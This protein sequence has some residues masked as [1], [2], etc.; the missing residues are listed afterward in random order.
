MKN[1][2]YSKIKRTLAGLLLAML[3]II[4][5]LT[6]QGMSV[7]AEDDIPES[8]VRY[9][10]T[11]PDGTVV[12]ENAEGEPLSYNDVQELLKPA[13]WK[14]MAEGL[15]S[16]ANGKVELD[17]A[18][19]EGT[20]RIVETKVPAGYTQGDDSE[21]TAE[22]EDGTVKFVNPKEKDPEPESGATYEITYDLNGGEYDGST[23]DIVEYYKEG[24][25]ISIHEAPERKGYEF[26]YWKG[27]EY[28]PGDSYTVTEDHT[29]TAQ[30][31]KETTTTT[32]TSG[33]T[34]TGDGN[35]LA[36]YILIGG[37]AAAIF[38]FLAFKKKK[39]RAG[40]ISMM[41][42]GVFAIGA[43]YAA[44]GF[45]INKIDD[46]GDPVKG[47]VFDIYGKPEVT[48][49]DIET[50][51]INGKKTWPDD[52]AVKMG[53]TIPNSI[54]VT[55]QKKDD[56][57]KDV[58]TKTVSKNAATGMWTYDF[59][60]QPKYNNGTEIEYRVVE[61]PVAGY[62][63]SGGTAADSY[64]LTNEYDSR[65]ITLTK[66]WAGDSAAPSGT[67]PDEFM[68]PLYLQLYR[69]DEHWV[70]DAPT[71]DVV[72]NGDN[73][74]T[75]TYTVPR[76]D[77]NGTEYEYR[78]EE[79]NI[80]NYVEGEITGS[81]DNGFAVTNTYTAPTPATVTIHGQKKWVFGA[82]PPHGFTVPESIRV[83]LMAKNNDSGRWS[84]AVPVTGSNP[85][86]VSIDSDDWDIYGDWTSLDISEGE[87]TWTV[88]EKDSKGR[89][90]EYMVVEDTVPY[91]SKTG[92][93]AT[94]NYN[95]T[96][97]YDSSLY[98]ISFIAEYELQGTSGTWSDYISGN[99]D[100]VVKNE[101]GQQVAAFNF[102][103]KTGGITSGSANLAPGHYTVEVT[104]L[105]ADD[106]TIPEGSV[107]RTIPYQG[108]KAGGFTVD[109][110]GWCVA[111]EEYFYEDATVLI[112]TST[113]T[114]SVNAQTM[115][116][117]IGEFIMADGMEGNEIDLVFR[118]GSVDDHDV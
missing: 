57:W 9:T 14:K 30:W 37:A 73:T 25:V 109:E 94:D 12:T 95:I 79:L 67:R 92:G 98:N 5:A 72:D 114:K 18:W 59:G 106:L 44:D 34:K 118:I 16:D 113:G 115:T 82:N 84:Q 6:A 66:T 100:V 93:T 28:Q 85:L 102:N 43:A 107:E 38:S 76:L 36:I 53:W 45:V 55:L 7:Y 80:L 40:V 104:P 68:F 105:S 27:S 22:L 39:V 23:E 97:T 3:A 88:P 83:T 50:I 1:L 35:N 47:A 29:F 52:E 111:D 99:Q 31:I 56:T 2:Y 15:A 48:C 70:T 49:E 116:D 41:L 63:A 74:Y 91:F 75:V 58:E 17:A 108:L 90:I 81:M 62:K 21:K 69:N 10:L 51:S 4:M 71:P 103:G 13:N 110:D 87:W 33:G 46:N 11:Y 64:N 112:N 42:I 89:T 26:D 86:D 19:K 20:I 54:D 24:E 96:N 77:E 61:K 117:N 32:T 60:Q 8:G 78:I 65:T 101:I